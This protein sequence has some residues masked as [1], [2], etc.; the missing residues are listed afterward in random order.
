[1]NIIITGA[2]KGIGRALAIKFAQEG[3][4]LAVCARTAD[5]LS[6][7]KATLSTLNPKIQVHAFACDVSNKTELDAF[8]N[9]CNATFSNIDIL[10]NNAGVFRPGNLMDEPDDVLP[11]LINTNLY[12]AYYLTRHIVPNMRKHGSGHIF[13]ICSVAS[14]NAYD[15]GGSYAISKFALY[16][17]SKNLRKELQKDHIRVTS[18]LPGAT[19]TESWEGTILPESRFI[20]VTDV[21]TLIYQAWAVS[22]RTVVEDLIIRPMEGDI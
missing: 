5:A 3:F 18:V 20:D 6:E 22:G 2:T 7:L 11:L 21:A 1:M 19:Y 15:A 16:G 12:S 17:F 13:N 8:G 14:V 4:N 10:V 9:F